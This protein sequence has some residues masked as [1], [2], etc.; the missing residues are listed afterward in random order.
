VAAK[1][2]LERQRA[3]AAPEKKER[4]YA[5]YSFEEQRLILG[6][7]AETQTDAR[8]TAAHLIQHYKQYLPKGVTADAIRSRILVSYPKGD[9][10]RN[11][12]QLSPKKEADPQA[13][14]IRAR[15]PSASAKPPAL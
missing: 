7:H 9:R 15:S 6:V 8:T 4:K 10:A 11:S 5:K 3:A 12:C 13:A 14:R 1:E 2:A